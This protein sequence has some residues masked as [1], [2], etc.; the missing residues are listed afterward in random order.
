MAKSN[1]ET[2]LCGNVS[3]FGREELETVFTEQSVVVMARD[4]RTRREGRI[5]WKEYPLTGENFQRFFLM[6][7]FSTVIYISRALT[8]QCRPE[9][10]LTELRHVLELC[11]KAGTGRFLFITT[12]HMEE[13]KYGTDAV[14]QKTAEILCHRYTDASEIELKIIRSP[15]FISGSNPQDWLYRSFERLQRGESI[16]LR[17]NP[18]EYAGFIGTGDLCQAL[19]RV[20]DHWQTEEEDLYLLPCGNHTFIELALHLQKPFTSKGG[21]VLT[22]PRIPVHRSLAEAKEAQSRGDDFMQRYYGWYAVRDCV[23]EI[24]QCANE[25]LQHGTGTKSRKERFLQF[26]AGKNRAIMLT[27]LF[28]GAV[29]AE[30]LNKLTGSSAQFRVI[31]VRLLFVV[32][33]ASTYGSGVGFAAAFLEILSLA[34][35]YYREGRN[36]VQLFYDP[37]NWL[38]FILL[39]LVS[40]VCGYLHEKSRDTEQELQEEVRKLESEVQFSTE[41]CYEAQQYKNDYK[42]RLI[43]SRDGF[44][45][46]FE[47]VERLSHTIPE[48]I[49]AEAILAMEEVLDNHSIAIYSI[50]DE[51]ARFARME[52][53]S[54]GL[55][56]LPRSIET[57]KYGCLMPILEKEEVWVNR[58]LDAGYPML[59]TGIRQEGTYRLLIMVYHA[60]YNQMTAYYV[61]LLRILRR[62]M[63]QCLTRAYLYQ[64]ARYQETYIDDTI[65]VR[66]EYLAQQEKIRRDME[67]QHVGTYSILCIR[68]GKRSNKEIS[69]ML[70]KTIRT[71]DVA[72]VG[73]DGDIYLIAAQSDAKS[74]QIVADRYA[75]MGLQVQIVEKLPFAPDTGAAAG[76]EAETDIAG[77]YR[78]NA[79]TGNGKAPSA[80]KGKEEM[81]Q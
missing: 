29:C 78:K 18:Q 52:V 28:L 21:R 49:Y 9:E 7:E 77:A 27:E 26:I 50:T 25:F 37:A 46:I 2:L 14:F 61:N 53:S 57:E 81:L 11:R 74:A 32:I 6:C 62:L 44:G 63:E 33:M 47:V 71:T 69:D 64:Q 15:Y 60:E 66:A 40:A 20:L 35:A 75:Q 23:G 1:E 36:W 48:R 42:Q 54:A 17:E 19:Y 4:V 13:E 31:D 67:E 8:Y 3:Y 51:K 58:E 68:R 76:K 72:G 12:A 70:E 56:D 38:P 30:I 10:E 43:E 55:K 41:L 65:L 73:T 79:K 59:L 45:R 16:H 39:L 80:L 24:E 34:A 22:D 5:S